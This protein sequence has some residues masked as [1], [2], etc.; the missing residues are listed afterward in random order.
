MSL[1]H[2][3]DN[4]AAHGRHGDDTLIHVDK[5]EL[6]ALKALAAKHGK[7]LTTNPETGLPEA[8]GLRQL[9]PAAVGFALAGPGGMSAMEAGLAVGGVSAMASGNLKQGMMDGLG[10]WGAANLAAAPAAAATTGT[11]STVGTAAQ[12]ALPEVA[13][14]AGY[15]PQLASGT[16]L[17]EVG[18][19][20]AANTV[21]TTGTMG[22][23]IPGGT[24]AENY[25]WDPLTRA[26]VPIADPATSL[27]YVN[28]ADLGGAG[29]SPVNTGAATNAAT[30]APVAKQSLLSTI[31]ANAEANPK[32]LMG[33]LAP[34][35]G[36]EL[37]K[38]PEV[39]QP[40]SQG[41]A[42]MGQRFQYLPSSQYA[43]PSYQKISNE[44]AKKLYG[45]ADGGE[46]QYPYEQ[47][48]VRM[49]KGGE[50]GKHQAIID[51]FNHDYGAFR[52]AALGAS[53]PFVDGQ[54]GGSQQAPAQQY[55]YHPDDQSYTNMAAGGGISALGGYSDGGRLLKGP[56][57]GMSDNIPA[58]IG[59]KQPARL[60]DGEFVVPADVVSHLGNG[61]TD[62]GAKQLYKMMDKVRAARTGNKH[63]GKQINPNKFT[64]A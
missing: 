63:Q 35:I 6:A 16:S 39:A 38:K 34:A 50:A 31:A 48:I 23:Q 18:G 62:A 8:F 37:F 53:A 21:S 26:N 13:T 61:S 4:M 9:L 45:Y 51:A 42:D 33:A 15:T 1:K 30:G 2:L 46:V 59:Q 25:T 32:Y 10:A 14:T 27:N 52:G 19:L 55:A 54:A 58:Q 47:P 3:A 5:G 57:D 40:K 49:A 20:N 7:P 64:P 17:S 22:S 44:Q 60:A 11:A 29:S 28:G 36:E 12:T 43:A 56:G 24:L 41:D